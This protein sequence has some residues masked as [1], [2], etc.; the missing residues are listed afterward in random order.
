MGIVYRAKR[1]SLDRVEAVKIMAPAFSDDPQV[2]TR[3]KLEAMHAAIANHPHVVTVY[4][5]E[6]RDGRL[7]IAM[8]YIGGTDLKTRISSDGAVPPAAAA[9]ITRQVASRLM[10]HIRSASSTATSSQRTYCSPESAGASM[11]T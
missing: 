1:I 3:F 11:R 10:P 6:E 2:R 5:A 8:Q 4:D 7:Y 9:G